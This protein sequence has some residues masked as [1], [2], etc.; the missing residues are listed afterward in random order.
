MEQDVII[1]CT[2][3]CDQPLRYQKTANGK[4]EIIVRGITGFGTTT[5]E[6]E[7]YIE[8]EFDEITAFNSFDEC[9]YVVA[10]KGNETRL[11]CYM[12]LNF[13]KKHNFWVEKDPRLL[14]CQFKLI[15][16]K[17]EY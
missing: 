10:K 15:N 9:A 17:R 8:D 13:G 11:Y 5:I 16:T 14:N 2:D 4:Y 3:G 7:R 1:N 12:T 6:Y